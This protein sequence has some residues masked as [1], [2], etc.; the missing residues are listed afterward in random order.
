MEYFQYTYYFED[1][2]DMKHNNMLGLGHV[3]M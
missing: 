2:Q 1:E 3:I